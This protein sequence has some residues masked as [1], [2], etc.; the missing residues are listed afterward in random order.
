MPSFDRCLVPESTLVPV[1]RRLVFDGEVQ[2]ASASSQVVI[3]WIDAFRPGGAPFG[4]NAVAGPL[5]VV[6]GP[7]QSVRRTVRLRIPRSASAAP[8]FQ[9]DPFRSRDIFTNNPPGY[10]LRG[11]AGSLQV[12]LVASSAFQFAGY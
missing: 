3:A 12:C 9:G 6:L 2:N 5:T 10:S 1:G 11:N 7:N 4:R 8:A